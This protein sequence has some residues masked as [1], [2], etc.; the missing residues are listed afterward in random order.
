MYADRVRDNP[1]LTVMPS[2]YAL[3]MGIP[4]VRLSGSNSELSVLCWVCFND[5]LH[6]PPI[7]RLVEFGGLRHQVGAARGYI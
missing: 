1:D 6:D 3:S 2:P 7:G 4:T 5:P